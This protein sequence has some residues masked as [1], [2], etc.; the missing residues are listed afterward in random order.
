MMLEMKG[1]LVEK[2]DNIGHGMKWKVNCCQAVEN[3]H[4]MLEAALSVPKSEPCL[5]VGH[6]YLLSCFYTCHWCFEPSPQS[7]RSNSPGVLP[8]HLERCNSPGLLDCVV[9]DMRLLVV[10]QKVQYAEMY[11]EALNLK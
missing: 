9:D 6:S 3:E 10:K 7:W 1:E 4:L 11:V 8:G 5:D 2:V